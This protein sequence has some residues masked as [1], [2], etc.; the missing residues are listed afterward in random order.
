MFGR[1]SERRTLRRLGEALHERAVD[2]ARRP[3]LFLEGGVEDT[4]DGRFEMLSL[5]MAILLDRVQPM[6]PDGPELARA[7]NEAFVAAMDDTMRL[8]GIG[9]LAVPRKVKKA[10]GA[11]FDRVQHFAPA[12]TAADRKIGR[13][14]LVKA[15][16]ELHNQPGLGGLNAETVADLAIQFA[17][18]LAALPDDVLRQ[19]TAGP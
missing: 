17:D 8:F 16:K 12:L 2:A 5:H 7:T 3:A 19:P 9:D 13:S 4:T 10:A 11:L 1:W 18:E 15:L 14:A 6:T